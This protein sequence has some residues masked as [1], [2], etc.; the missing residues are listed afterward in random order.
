MPSEQTPHIPPEEEGGVNF[1]KL[2]IGLPLWKA[3]STMLAVESAIGT[4][5]LY[6]CDFSSNR[7]AC[8][9]TVTPPNRKLKAHLNP[10]ESLFYGDNRPLP[11]CSQA[12]RS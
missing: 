3:F 2:S 1:L 8:T 5:A 11:R 4:E 10:T 7:H 9:N 6:A 12:G